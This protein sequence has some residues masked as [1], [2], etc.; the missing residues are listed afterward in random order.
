MYAH[1]YIYIYHIYVY[2]NVCIIY[3]SY[4]ATHALNE[5]LEPTKS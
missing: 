5:A 4:V 3:P 1:I 2:I